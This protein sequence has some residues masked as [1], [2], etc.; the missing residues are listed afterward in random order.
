MIVYIPYTLKCFLLH[1]PFL[2][3]KTHAN[4]FFLSF[5]YV[6]NFFFSRGYESETNNENSVTEW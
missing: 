1:L 2:K 4:I 3:G 6:C 5:Q